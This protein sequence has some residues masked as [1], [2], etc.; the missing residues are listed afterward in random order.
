MAAEY[1][2][3]MEFHHL[4]FRAVLDDGSL[5]TVRM[6]VVDRYDNVD[7]SWVLRSISGLDPVFPSS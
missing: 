7:G 4:T 2:R 5:H 1:V 3:G 6:R